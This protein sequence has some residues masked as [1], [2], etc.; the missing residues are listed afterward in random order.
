MTHR[1]VLRKTSLTELLQ[2][3]QQAVGES[4][5]PMTQQGIAFIYAGAAKFQS[6]PGL[7]A[8]LRLCPHVV[9]HRI[10]GAIR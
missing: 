5:K 1:K 4:R 9:R 3:L 2:G 7:T 8:Q 6:T 10:S